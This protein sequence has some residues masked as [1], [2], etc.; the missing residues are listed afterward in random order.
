MPKIWNRKS[1]KKPWT[2]QYILRRKVQ[3][4]SFIYGTGWNAATSA[5][6][7][8]IQSRLVLPSADLRWSGT[9]QG[10]LAP[11]APATACRCAYSWNVRSTSIADASPET[12]RMTDDEEI[13]WRDMT[14]YSR[15][16]VVYATG[17]TQPST[18]Q[19]YRTFRRDAMQT[20]YMPRPIFFSVW[21][22]SHS[23]S[24]SK[25]LLLIFR[26]VEAE[27]CWNLPSKLMCSCE[28]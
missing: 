5:W 25:R 19:L 18:V 21:G 7:I 24:V 22:L 16:S 15:R 23:S 9:D 14:K 4:Q 12:W 28:I 13:Q 10:C 1:F 17:Y 11:D 27:F 8:V 20:Q 3:L 6:H 26:A 2:I